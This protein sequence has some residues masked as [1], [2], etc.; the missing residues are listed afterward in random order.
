LPPRG[1]GRVGGFYGG[2]AKDELGALRP[3]LVGVIG[4]TVARDRVHLGMLVRRQANERIALFLHG[5]I[6]RYRQ[7]GGADHDLTLP[8]SRE[9]IASYLGLVLETVSRGF[10]RLQDD[11]VIEVHG[12]KVRVA[13]PVALRKLAHVD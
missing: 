12:R 4:Q 10:T 9:D 13:D 3:Q 8:M 7:R 6:E 5:L 1:N 11:G 2:P